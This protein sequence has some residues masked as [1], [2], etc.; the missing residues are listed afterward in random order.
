MRRFLPIIL[1]AVFSIGAVIILFSQVNFEEVIDNIRGANGL[2]LL[3]MGLVYPLSMVIRSV[4]WQHFL[5]AHL[6]FWRSFHITNI[7][8][9]FNAVLPFRLGEFARILLMSREPRHSAGAGLSALTLE[10]L[11]DLSFALMCVGLGLALLPDNAALPAETTSTL[12]ILMVITIIGGMVVI[13][14]PR[15]HP[16]ILR[17]LHII[18]RPLPD[19]LAHRG[20]KF[21]EDTLNGLQIIATPRRLF[22][23]LILT[24]ITWSTYFAFFHVGLFAFLEKS[25][26]LGVGFLVTGFVALGIA[27][28]SLPG[29]IGVFQAAAVLAL[30]TAGYDTAIATSYSW[31]LW[32]VEIGAIVLGGI[33][34]LSAMGLSFGRLTREVTSQ[35]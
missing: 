3:I 32:V 7:G 31:T 25:P 5:Q 21:V 13:F 1:G 30:T 24:T 10:R 26:T 15:T 27:A 33:W 17:I 35:H 18:S 12:G 23:T 11:L 20:I 2:Y 29:A 6:P 34:G 22:N 28:P 16:F 19:S 14:L 8:Y 4:R 9:F